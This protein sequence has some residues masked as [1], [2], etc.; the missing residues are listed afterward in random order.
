MIFAA[1]AAALFITSTAALASGLDDGNAGLDA[2]DSKQYAEAVR[3]L[4]RAINS[5]DL[6]LG[7]KEL[8]Y[9]SRGQA[10]LGE[11]N[12]KSAI[13]DIEHALKLKPDD[14]DAKAALADASATKGAP[15]SSIAEPERRPATNAWGI[16]ASLA[17]QYW[18]QIDGQP[19]QYNQY[20]WETP[21]LI[22]AYTG[23]DRSGNV[24]VG[25][26]QLD[27]T[28]SQISD[29]TLYKGQTTLGTV[30]V[31]PDH[32]VE[33]GDQRGTH[34]RL[35]Y[36]QTSAGAFQ[37]TAQT[38]QKGEWHTAKTIN[39]VQ[40]SSDFVQA[41]SWKQN[42]GTS[43]DAASS[44]FRDLGSAIKQGALTGVAN[45]VQQRTQDA[46]TPP[47]PPPP[48]PPKCRRFEANC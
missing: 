44:F 46:I 18:M 38:L 35:T 48:P 10:Y 30:E 20:K 8:A 17:G 41:L 2:L 28:T 47:P 36:Q 13:V 32:F 6:P 11:G 31:A 15:R 14:P 21:G 43:N 23:L 34:V 5:G 29:L 39:V 27:P 26:F 40:V 19:V 22:L 16:L 4:T 37:V 3:L 33:E 24:I 12:R 45:G 1:V 9:L 7:Q 42:A 25:R